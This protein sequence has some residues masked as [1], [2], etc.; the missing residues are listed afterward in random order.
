[1]LLRSIGRLLGIIPASVQPPLK[2]ER[3]DNAEDAVVQSA[4][5]SSRETILCA[6]LETH[7][8]CPQ[9]VYLAPP[10]PLYELGSDHAETVVFAVHDVMHRAP[11]P[12]VVSVEDML[13]ACVWDSALVLHGYNW[14][15]A[16]VWVLQLDVCT[17]HQEHM[18][19]HFRMIS[20][21]AN[22]NSRLLLVYVPQDV[23]LDGVERAA[24]FSNGLSDFAKM[25]GFEVQT[26]VS[27]REAGRDLDVCGLENLESTEA[28]NISGIHIATLEHA[29]PEE[30]VT[31][32]HADEV[33][34]SDVTYTPSA[35]VGASAITGSTCEPSIH[36]DIEQYVPSDVRLVHFE[37]DVSPLPEHLMR[38]EYRVIII[39]S[40]TCIGC[41]DPQNAK[42]MVGQFADGA[43]VLTADLGISSRIEKLEYKYA[44]LNEHG[45]VIAWENGENRFLCEPEGESFAQCISDRWRCE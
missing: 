14:Q 7:L 2:E 41:W 21:L 31:L 37:L 1:M 27:L 30:I 34:I 33:D 11:P 3:D 10:G 12:P 18:E 44:V 39:G 35:S 15:I 16:S 19:R 38:T 13:D 9:I 26:D 5:L 22:N 24:T 17:L 43:E 32:E 42:K 45:D 36:G 25:C 23:C 8:P 6:A 28:D 4:P 29:K 40:E 20:N